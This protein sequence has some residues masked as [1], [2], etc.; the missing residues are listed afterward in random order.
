VS[1]NGAIT[2]FDA[3]NSIGT[4]ANN[5]TPGGTIVGDYYDTNSVFHGYVRTPTGAFIEFSVPGAG[6]GADQ[7]T[8]AAYINSTGQITGNYIDS[9]GVSHGFLRQ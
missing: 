3:P 4:S 1:L 6:T 5:I 8:V 9:S 2:T 7:G